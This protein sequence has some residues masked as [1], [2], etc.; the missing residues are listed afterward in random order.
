MFDSHEHDDGG[1][2]GSPYE[3][4]LRLAT[5]IASML[6]AALSAAGP[7]DKATHNADM[8][9]AM[10]LITLEILQH[11]YGPHEVGNA[12]K[13]LMTHAEHVAKAF[14]LAAREHGVDASVDFRTHVGKMDR[15]RPQ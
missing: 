2:D 7:K 11:N 13:A 14:C 9:T 4:H 5:S 3:L 8:M 15:D 12:L 10:D 1:D 6:C